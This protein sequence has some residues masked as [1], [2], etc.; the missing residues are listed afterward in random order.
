MIEGRPALNLDL[1]AGSDIDTDAIDSGAANGMDGD[2]SQSEAERIDSLNDRDS[3]HTPAND[4]TD[5]A[6]ARRALNKC[7]I[8]TGSVDAEFSYNHD[9]S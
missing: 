1:A 8:R 2:G 7:G 9:K 4:N 6:I 3:R 5:I